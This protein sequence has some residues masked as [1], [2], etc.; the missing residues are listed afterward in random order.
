MCSSKEKSRFT[1]IKD[2]IH[3]IK[4][5]KNRN[6]SDYFDVI[7]GKVVDMR[8]ELKEIE[9]KYPTER[10]TDLYLENTLDPDIPKQIQRKQEKLLKKIDIYSKE[11]SRE[12]DRNYISN[13]VFFWNFFFWLFR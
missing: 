6:S 13:R 10:M 4:L 5:G 9:L 2:F 11:L 12:Y 3:E 7:R 1:L 8:E